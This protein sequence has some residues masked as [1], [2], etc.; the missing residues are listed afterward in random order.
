MKRLVFA[1]AL[2]TACAPPIPPP[3][4][5]VTPSE[6]PPRRDLGPL[7]AVGFTADHV[8]QNGTSARPDGEPDYEFRVRISGDVRAMVLHGSDLTGKPLGLDVW[9]TLLAGPMNQAL[10]IP[11]SDAAATWVL[12][13]FD[14]KG[15]ALNPAVTLNQTFRDAT[16]HLF[17]ADPKRNSFVPNKTY[18]LLI[19]RN[20]GSVERTTTTIL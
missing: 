2:L 7:I 15:E 4:K 19:E 17:V 1:S 6:G 12:G 11:A 3:V 5:A 18:T 8:G 20:D 16:V 14:D 13:V 10:H 9:D